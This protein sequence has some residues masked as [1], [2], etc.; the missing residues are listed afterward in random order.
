MPRFDIQEQQTIIGTPQA[1]AGTFG[2]DQGLTALGRSVSNLGDVLAHAKK[3]RE[4]QKIANAS[5]Q[6]SS[7][8]QQLS[9]DLEN[10]PDFDTHQERYDLGVQDIH[11]QVKESL[12]DDRLFGIFKQD[13][14]PITL[15]QGFEVQRGVISRQRDQA[16]AD[17]TNTTQAYSTLAARSLDETE[18][19]HYLTQGR[20]A[21][22]TQLQEGILTAVEAEKLDQDFTD[23]IQLADIRELIRVDADTAVDELLN[24]N[25]E[26]SGLDENRRQIWIER[27]IS[28]QEANTK[29]RLADEARQQRELD[30]EQKELEE[31]TAKDADIL[32]AQ[33]ELTSNWVIE[34]EDNLSKQD[35]RHFLNRL[36]GATGR[37]TTSPFIFSDLYE[38]SGSGENVKDEARQFLV[39]GQMSQSDYEK[40][41]KRVEDEEIEGQVPSW[42][43]RG[44]AFINTSLKPSDLNEDAFA[45]VRHADAVNEWRVWAE[46]HPNVSFEEAEKEY[47]RLVDG[48]LLL[49][50]EN[51]LAGKNQPRFFSGDR[52]KMTLENVVQTMQKTQQALDSG[53]L[54]ESEFKREIMKL[55]EFKRAIEKSQAAKGAQQ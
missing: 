46:N 22:Q 33:G 30:N 27:A 2:G 53:Q 31:A 43:K 32:L 4:S 11:R 41:V 6:A 55:R 15:K 8:L 29:A 50:L 21:I 42:F 54:D 9:F 52:T 51:Q 7:Q 37:I 10:D 23:N 34:N 39:S 12:N 1:A 25:G 44:E 5:A 38:R 14:E 36:S 26:F 16:K 40:I 17:L 35:F 20:V 45:K 49:N 18:R 13:F 19:D 24:P 47:K 3:A 28:A 48:A